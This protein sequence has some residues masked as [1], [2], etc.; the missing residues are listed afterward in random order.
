M[1]HND[2]IKQTKSKQKGK[3]SRAKYGIH[4][5]KLWHSLSKPAQRA[6][7]KRV[8][9][10]VCMHTFSK[11]SSSVSKFVDSVVISWHENIYLKQPTEIFWILFAWAAYKVDHGI[12]A[13]HCRPRIGYQ[14]SAKPRTRLSTVGDRAFP[15]AAAACVWNEL[16]RH[17]TSA[18][19]PLRV[20]CSRL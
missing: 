1:T 18:P 12:W 7:Q 2:T 9:E 3:Y 10:F 14:R 5:R 19:S 20:F 8:F 6:K 4:G 13:T 15:V 11:K 17:V 16:P